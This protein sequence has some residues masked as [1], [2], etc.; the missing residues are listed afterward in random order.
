MNINLGKEL[1][2]FIN[3]Q[4]AIDATYSTASEWVRDAIRKKIEGERSY[5]E[6]LNALKADI[7][8]GLQQIENGQFVDVDFDT[9]MK[10]TD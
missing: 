7:D 6:Q 8:S 3:Q 2:K 4:V 10:E 1:E 5:H 9:L